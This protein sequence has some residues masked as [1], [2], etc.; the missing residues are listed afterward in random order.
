MTYL[1]AGL[2]IQ[3]II[4]GNKTSL[5]SVA[6]NLNPAAN[7]LKNHL[8]KTKHPAF[9]WDMN[10]NSNPKKQAQEEFSVE[11]L[12]KLII[13]YYSKFCQIIINL[14]ISRIGIRH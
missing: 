8:I 9:P 10:F 7:D 3:K 2:Q 1:I 13:L 5:F 11:Q 12:I 14:K 4:F 6:Q